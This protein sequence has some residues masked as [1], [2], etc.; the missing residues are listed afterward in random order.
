MAQQSARKTVRD[1]LFA[2]AT[3]KGLRRST[4]LSY[5]RLL[6]ILDEVEVSQ[7]DVLSRLWTIDRTSTSH[8]ATAS[9]SADLSTASTVEAYHLVPS[10][11]VASPSRFSGSAMPTSVCPSRRAETMRAVTSAGR[12][13]GRPS[14]FP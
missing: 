4:V 5:E 9:S 11:A 3:E 7:E 6:G 10:R 12:V 8:A 1:R 13:R 2:V 14:R